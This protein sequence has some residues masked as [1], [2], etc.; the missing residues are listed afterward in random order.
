MG[1]FHSYRLF[2]TNFHLFVTVIPL[3]LNRWTRK[4]IMKESFNGQG[5]MACF[6][7]DLEKLWT[8]PLM[9]FLITLC[10]NIFIALVHYKYTPSMLLNLLFSGQSAAQD[11]SYIA[12]LQTIEQDGVWFGGKVWP[13]QP[14][15]R[16]TVNTGAS[17]I[18]THCSGFMQQ[19]FQAS[20]NVD[21]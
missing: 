15:T 6:K 11:V 10:V 18:Y 21:K 8:Y 20:H 2:S 12:R 3:Q 5:H 4:H 1:I 16:P 17:F 7:K 9:H 13:L 19:T 14:Q